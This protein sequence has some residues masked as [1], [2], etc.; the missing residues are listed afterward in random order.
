MTSNLRL[1]LR[2]TCE[3]SSLA[4]SCWLMRESIVR[5]SSWRDRTTIL[6]EWIGCNYDHAMIVAFLQ[7]I[8]DI[9]LSILEG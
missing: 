2:N 5:M 3:F 6:G 4:I 7:D 1:M 8:V 9:M